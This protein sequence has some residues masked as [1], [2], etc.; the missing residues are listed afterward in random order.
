M[1]IHPFLKP[2]L[3]AA[4][5]QVQEAF[6]PGADG[7]PLGFADMLAFFEGLRTDLTA[8]QQATTQLTQVTQQQAVVIDQLTTLLNG[9]ASASSLADVRQRVTTAETSLLGKA[10]A[11]AVSQQFQ[12]Q[13]GIDSGQAMAIAGLK[14]ILDTDDG[15]LKGILAKQANYDLLLPALRTDVDAKAASAA[16]SALTGQVTTL[17]NAV[18]DPATGLAVTNGL[19]ANAL[20]LSGGTLTGALNVQAPTTSSNPL[21]FN[22]LPYSMTFSQTLPLVALGALYT[23]T[24]TVVNAQVG[25]V[26]VLN[27]PTTLLNLGTSYTAVVSAANTVTIQLKA[28]AAVAAGA[29]TFYLRVLR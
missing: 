27:L 9:K 13:T 2:A 22:A 16:V 29:Q 10:D 8:A 14:S 26:V 20:P 21:Q 19:A 1:T 11:A 24:V 7:K 12:A 6:P 23:F 18:N 17:R 4:V 28:G 15:L 25:Q 5:S 3:Q